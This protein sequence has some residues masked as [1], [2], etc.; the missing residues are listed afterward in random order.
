MTSE[1]GNS[2]HEAE[3]AVGENRPRDSRERAPVYVQYEPK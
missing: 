3:A 2:L 1:D